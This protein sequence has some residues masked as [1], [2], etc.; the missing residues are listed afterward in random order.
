M[1]WDPILL[2]RRVGVIALIAFL[3]HPASAQNS[4]D[5]EQLLAEADRLAWLKAWT[6]AEP[7]YTAAAREFAARGDKRNALYAQIN[8]LRGQLPRLSVPEVSERLANLLEDPLVLADDRLRL[9]TL[10]IKGET[11]EDLDPSLSEQSWNEALALAEKLGESA[12]ANRARGE[13]GLV[14]FL[15]GDINNAVIRLGQAMK[16]AESNGDV[17][18]LVRW[19]TLFGT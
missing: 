7:L 8:A 19:L 6:K 4:S 3:C 5:P 14:A 12:W 1:S 16:V 15:S 13:L 2:V 18:S 11:D 9:R 17:A 10:I